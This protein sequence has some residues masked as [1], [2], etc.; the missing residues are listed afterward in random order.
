ML[1]K[2]LGSTALAVVTASLLLAPLASTSRSQDVMRRDCEKDKTL[3]KLQAK[4]A[5]DLDVLANELSV[6]LA[7]DAT[8]NF[9]AEAITKGKK[10]TVGL[11]QALGALR[12][13]DPNNSGKRVEATTKIVR[14]IESAMTEPVRWE[15]RSAGAGHNRP[16]RWRL[17]TRQRP[18][19]PNGCAAALDRT[20][21]PP[22]PALTGAGRFE[23][24]GFRP[25]IHPVCVARGP[26]HPSGPGRG[27]ARK[28]GRERNH[29]RSDFSPAGS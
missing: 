21:R 15:P 24:D 7:Q 28:G 27:A 23:S 25:L 19:A 8:R 1:R 18:G 26:T 29:S 3:A 10:R 12:V 20:E 4:V 2:T 13:K 9:F 14:K 22:I 16:G 17:D 5:S 6:M 11:G